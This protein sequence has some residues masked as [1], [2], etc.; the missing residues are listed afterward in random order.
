[1]A[2]KT[3]R[4][5]KTYTVCM[6]ASQ[7]LSEETAPALPMYNLRILRVLTRA[8]ACQA[9]PN[10]AAAIPAELANSPAT[11]IQTSLSKPIHLR[12]ECNHGME[13]ATNQIA[14][15]KPEV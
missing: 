3:E 1:M 13:A 4:P 2:G 12:E 7:P 8:N 10:R 15:A 11:S 14:N 9:I 5:L 6:K